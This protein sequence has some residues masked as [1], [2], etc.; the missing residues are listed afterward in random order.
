VKICYYFYIKEKCG[1]LVR[2]MDSMD[3]LASVEVIS[4]T[5]IDYLQL[6]KIDGNWKI[7]NVLW[8]PKPTLQQ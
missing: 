8:K 7:V 1:I 2:I 6:A 3:N 4:A 5:L